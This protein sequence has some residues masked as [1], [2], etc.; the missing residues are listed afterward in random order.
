MKPA[1]HLMNKLNNIENILKKYLTE[2]C[3][4]DA[5]NQEKFS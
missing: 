2:T 5:N 1:Q 4:E 3:S